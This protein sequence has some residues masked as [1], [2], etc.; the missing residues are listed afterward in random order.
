MRYEEF[1]TRL[2]D[3]RTHQTLSE[4]YAVVHLF[5][6]HQCVDLNRS[7]YEK[8]IRADG[9]EFIKR[10]RKI[11]PTAQCKASAYPLIRLSELRSVVLVHEDLKAELT[12]SGITGVRFIPLDQIM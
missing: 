9:S 4:D 6:C 3:R 12:R 8:G 5:E 10:F 1:P 11:V 7:D 2:I